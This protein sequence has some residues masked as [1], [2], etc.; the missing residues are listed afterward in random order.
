MNPIDDFIQR[1]LAAYDTKSKDKSQIIDI[2]FCFIEQDR[3]FMREYIDLIGTA[4]K[5]EKSRQYVNSRIARK[6]AEHYELTL[7]ERAQIPES[8][9]IQGYS[10]LK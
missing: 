9:L 4:G 7:E 2:V 1:V 3:N 5:M 8:R 10:E 6:I